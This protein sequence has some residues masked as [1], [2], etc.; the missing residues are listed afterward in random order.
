MM[1]TQRSALAPTARP[2][3]LDRAALI[4]D[5]VSGLCPPQPGCDERARQAAHNALFGLALRVADSAI[6]G[7]AAADGEITLHNIRQRLIQAQRGDDAARCALC[8]GLGWAQTGVCWP[9]LLGTWRLAQLS[10]VQHV[11]P[12]HPN[13]CR[14]TA[15][16]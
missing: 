12:L 7:P 14:A 8:L 1:H 16:S 2:T 11:Q 9:L 4:D 6:A 13:R 5:L 10:C 15:D 3:Q